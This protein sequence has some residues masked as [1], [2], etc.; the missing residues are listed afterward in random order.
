ML[1][2]SVPLFICGSPVAVPAPLAPEVALTLA[3][4]H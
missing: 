4:T 2:E 3:A 1:N